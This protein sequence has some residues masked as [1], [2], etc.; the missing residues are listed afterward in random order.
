MAKFNH[1]TI[2]VEKKKTGT[3]VRITFIIFLYCMAEDKYNIIH[4]KRKREKK[5]PCMA[6]N[7]ETPAEKGLNAIFYRIMEYIFFGMVAP[8][9]LDKHSPVYP[10]RNGTQFIGE[11]LIADTNSKHFI[12]QD[13]VYGL[14][15]CSIFYEWESVLSV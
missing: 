1:L 3:F 11:N 7:R 6:R 2:K 15:G 13:K 14:L 8:T 12:R 5:I 4:I 10:E 9:Q